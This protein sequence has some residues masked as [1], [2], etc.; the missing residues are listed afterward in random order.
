MPHSITLSNLSWSTPDGHSLFNG[1]S[2]TL[3][4]ERTG[5]IGRNG[6]G[7]STLLRLIAAQTTPSAGTVSVTGRIGVL[8]QEVR[9]TP[10][11]TVADLFGVTDALAVL[12]RAEAGTATVEDLSIADWTLEDRIAAALGQIGLDADAA[13]PLASLSGGQRTRAGLAALIFDAPDILLL[14]EPTN[15]LDRDGRAAVLDLL[16]DWR[17][18]AV[19]VSHD[20]DVLRAVDA[21][22]ELTT[23]GA[24][25][26]GGGYD[27]YRAQKDLEL[28]AAAHDMATAE[29]QRDEVRRA[30]QARA[31]RKA[32]TDSA[33]RRLRASGSQGKML[34]DKAKE[35]SEASGG[36]SARLAETRLADAEDSPDNARSRIEVLETVKMDLPSSGL[37]AGRQVLTVTDLHAGYGA[38]VLR[39]LSLAVVGPERI[40]VTG[41]NGVGKS[42]LLKVL[43]GALPAMSGTAAV[44]VPYAMLD[45]SLGVLDPGMSVLDNYRARNPGDDVNAARAVLARFLFRGDAALVPAGRLSGGQM[46]RAGLACALGG[47][48]PELLILDEPTNHLDLGAIEALEAALRGYD[49]ALLVVSHDRAF[50]DAVGITREVA[51]GAVSAEALEHRPRE[52]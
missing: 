6:V 35:R 12:A 13:T 20:R 28:A 14:D 17:G 44:H 39:A 15:N 25:R 45:Q 19:V 34:M 38:P 42:T 48:P 32:R 9:P 31:E 41:P 47:K 7:K 1:L 24:T 51:L 2:L 43:T 26:Y 4:P 11:E 46:L 16:A 10:G 5:L 33:G 49:G 21:I 37:P 29:R 3:G 8:R 40:A 23:L 30:A 50:L 27:L 36:A 22:V 18:A 52:G